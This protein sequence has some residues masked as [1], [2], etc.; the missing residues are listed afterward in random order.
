MNTCRNSRSRRRNK[1]K[2]TRLFVLMTA[3]A[4][5][6]AIFS[7]YQITRAYAATKSVTKTQ[8]IEQTA[9]VITVKPLPVEAEK[10]NIVITVEPVPRQQAAE[11]QEKAEETKK[12]SD[13]FIPLPVAMPES[14]Q[15][16]VFDICKNNNIS[17]T[18]VMAL[19]G[20]ES[21]FKKNA[22]SATGDSGYMQINDCNLETMRQRGFTDMNDTAQNV[23]AGVSMLCELFEEY[24]AGETHK[25]LMAYN[26]GPDSA[27]K[28]WKQGVTTSKYSR[29]VTAREAEYSAVYE[30]LKKAVKE[31]ETN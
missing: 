12:E 2:N 31:N 17:F 4:V 7:I 27:R 16:I 28:L 5:I 11:K 9:P 19:I 26:M 3:A 13:D 25:V 8:N 23:G 14:D 18:L 15:R 20:C 22:R 29:K 21:E 1:R 10:Q 6:I 24:G 30:E